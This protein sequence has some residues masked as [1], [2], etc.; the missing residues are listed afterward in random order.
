MLQLVWARRPIE[1]L[2]NLKAHFFFFFFLD[3]PHSTL[4]A[5][6][7]KAAA[8]T[9][10]AQADKSDV[11]E[12]ADPSPSSPGAACTKNIRAEPSS[13]SHRIDRPPP[14]PT[15]TTTTDPATT[16]RTGI[17]KTDKTDEQKSASPPP[18]STRS[19]ETCHQTT[20]Y[21]R[22]VPKARQS[23]R[24]PSPLTKT[25]TIQGAT[26]PR[27]GIVLTDNPDRRA[28]VSPPHPLATDNTASSAPVPKTGIQ[29]TKKADV[30]MSVGIS[31]PFDALKRYLMTKDFTSILDD[32]TSEISAYDL[33]PFTKKYTVKSEIAAHAGVPAITKPVIPSSGGYSSTPPPPTNK[34]NPYTISTTTN[35]ALKVTAPPTKQARVGVSGVSSPTSLNAMNRENPGMA[36]NTRQTSELPVKAP[37]PRISSYRLSFDTASAR[38]GERNMFL[39]L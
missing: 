9:E 7:A 19:I 6:R 22:F 12:P 14:P 11:Q 28:S 29:L 8:S 26:I 25:V 27:T 13:G 17:L 33:S 37:A 24:P 3:R 1:K 16:P 23:V 39:S 38:Y 5:S 18:P 21:L 20:P 10:C 35:E 15:T 34:Y 32:P 30:G 2:F 31:P 4:D 36:S